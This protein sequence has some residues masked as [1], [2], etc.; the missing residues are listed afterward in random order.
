MHKLIS[1]NTLSYFA[2]AILIS[3]CSTA[4]RATDVS[5]I[6]VPIAPYL[7]MT[8]QELATEQNSLVKEAQSVGAQVDDSYRSDKNTELVTWILFAPAAF[9]MDGNQKEASQL[10]SIKGQLDTVQE[11]QKVNKCSL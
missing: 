6:R 8:C 7:K 1:K 4:Q 5:A 3:G 11:A 9:W 10:A 2:L